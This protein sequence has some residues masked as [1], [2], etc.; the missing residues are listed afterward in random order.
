L[1]RLIATQEVGAAI[2]MP[3]AAPPTRVY[4]AGTVAAELDPD[5]LAAGLPDAVADADC[6]A[7]TAGFTVPGALPHAVTAS[8][9]PI[10]TGT[11]KRPALICTIAAFPGN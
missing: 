10:A 5:G 8:P 6:V 7:E 3:C 2:E 1:A 4:P 11:A 9:I